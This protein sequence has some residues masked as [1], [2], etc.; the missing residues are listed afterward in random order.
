MRRLYLYLCCVQIALPRMQS[1]S[2][3]LLPM[4]QSIHALCIFCL[5][6]F[7]VNT[8]QARPDQ[9]AQHCLALAMYWEARG[10]GE[11]GM[12]AVGSVVMNRVQDKRFPDSACA[13]VKQGGETAP[14]QFSWWCD[15][16]SDRPTN[17]RSWARAMHV[18]N[19]VLHGRR[20]DPTRGAL[21]FHS[22]S[23]NP[24]WR[25]KRSARVGD[26]IFYR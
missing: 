8:A 19:Q 3:T 24:G 25:L 7:A 11:K 20:S 1:V 22:T 21:F 15:G 6:T 5:A 17:K 26:H 2:L 4:P 10:E 9:Q 16:K 12:Y 23:V 13:V 18:A 14:C